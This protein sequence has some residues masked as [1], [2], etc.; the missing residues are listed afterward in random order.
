[1]NVGLFDFGSL[2]PADVLTFSNLAAASYVGEPI[3]DGWVTLD[4]D[5]IRLEEGRFAGSFDEETGLFYAGAQ[6]FFQAAARVMR[7]GDTLTVSFQGTSSPWEMAL[8]VELF[9]T[10][11]YVRNFSALLNGVADYAAAE[12]IEDIWVTGHSLGAAAV[13]ELEV[14]KEFFYGGAFEDATY[15]AF[16]S[17]ELYHTGDLLNVGFEN[18]W[19]FKSVERILRDTDGEIAFDPPEAGASRSEWIAAILEILANV[20]GSQPPFASATDGLAFYDDTFASAWFSPYAPFLPVN[21]DT[22]HSTVYYTDAIERVSASAFYDDMTR[23]SDVVVVATSDVV[24]VT[25]RNFADRVNEP[26]YYIGRN[27]D[28]RVVAGSADDSLEGFGG[29]DELDGGRGDDVLI[30]G[31]GEDEL[32][33]GRGDDHLFGEAHDDRLYGQNGDDR[34]AGGIGS[35]I[36][37]GGRHVD[38]YVFAEGDARAAD[39]D[40][41]R[42]LRLRDEIVGLSDLVQSE[43]IREAETDT[44]TVVY[45]NGYTL[46]ITGDAYA[47]GAGLAALD[48]GMLGVTADD[49]ALVA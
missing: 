16:A 48:S 3:P 46:V 29:D 31:R 42:L 28:D 11:I 47:Y 38:T 35:D 14:R 34:L 8:Y 25:A 20:S 45:D 12:G 2:T 5:D 9:N 27:A 13:N 15:V 41:I 21:T 18:D 7:S 49:L 19:V 43:V 39:V 22:V 32:T 37:I 23:D 4:G 6:T 33:G 24:E 40:T 36:L 26:T 10:Q 30:G 1:M 44:L 17:P